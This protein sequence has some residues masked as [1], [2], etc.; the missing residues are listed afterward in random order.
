MRQFK[1]GIVLYIFSVAMSKMIESNQNQLKDLKKLAK[2]FELKDF[3]VLKKLG[4]GQFGQVYLVNCNKNNRL[5]ALKC[6]SKA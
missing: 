3:A 4:E 6:I 1:K 2:S 5:Y